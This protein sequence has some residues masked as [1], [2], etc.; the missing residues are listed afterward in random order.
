MA[1]RWR[2][3]SVMVLVLSRATEAMILTGNVGA[4][5]HTLDRLLRLLHDVGMRRHFVSEAVEMAAFLLEDADRSEAAARLLGAAETLR[6][7]QGEPHG[8]TSA[9]SA[10]VR[11]CPPRVLEVLG[12]ERYAEEITRGHNMS[13]EE[14]VTYALAELRGETVKSRGQVPSDPLIGIRERDGDGV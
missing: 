7:A 11:A 1:G 12:A 5:R 2:M 8:G 13:A 10:A 14:A 6:D 4:A 9:V 3:P